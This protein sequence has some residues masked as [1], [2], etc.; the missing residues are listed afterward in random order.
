MKTLLSGREE[1]GKNQWRMR[2]K[3]NLPHEFEEIVGQSAPLLRMLDDVKTVGPSFA[4]VLILGETGTGKELVARAI[5]RLSSRG[6][7]RFVKV[8]CAA[9]P[10]ELL[11][12]ELF[13]HE[14][15]AFTHAVGQKIG[16]VELADNGTLFLDEVGDLPLH[17]QPKLLGMLQDHEFERLGAARTI[18]MNLRVIAATNRDL[19]RD[20]AEGR[21]R[22]DLLYRLNAFP[23]RVP[24]LRE[25]SA[26]I[27]LLVRH[28]L[29]KF[30]QRM[31][32]N[33][34]TIPEEAMNAMMNWKWPGNVRELEHFVE[35]AMILTEGPVLQA[36]IT[37]LGSTSEL[38]AGEDELRSIRRD[39]IIKIMR[40]TGG[41]VSG[42]N[43]AAAR[44]G[45]KRTTLQSMMQRLGITREEYED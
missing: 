10:A 24:S 2:E 38:S 35:R 22:R 34:E 31:N 18:R 41:V 3:I 7:A 12:S 1:P 39:H 21:F 28:F 37:E 17:V 44:L 23:I 4:T 16:R 45:L 32:K 8:N 27:P 9:I 29:R 15:G 6:T 30:A 11:E 43:G 42:K 19:S 26:D 14:K 20:V 36:P 5:H 33:V 13:G 40:E 25:R